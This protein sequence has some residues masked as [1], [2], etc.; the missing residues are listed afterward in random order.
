MIPLNEEDCIKFNEKRYV[1]VIL[2]STAKTKQF[3]GIKIS[4]QLNIKITEIDVDTQEEV[5][6]YDEEYTQISDL[7]LETKD[8]IRSMAIPDGQYKDQWDSLGAQGQRGNNLSEIAQTFQLQKFKT[9]NAAVVG[10]TSSY[11]SMSV[12]EGS[13]K[14]NVTEKI[15]NLFLSGIFFGNN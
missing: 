12:C 8:Y 3:P 5:G 11:G 10:I 1:Y 4:Q 14:V 9:M 15:H 2:D 6:S 7:V 13:S